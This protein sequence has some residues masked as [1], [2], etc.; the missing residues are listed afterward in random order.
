MPTPIFAFRLAET[1][2]AALVEMSKLYGAKNPSEFLREMVGAMCSG[3][4]ERVQEFNAR[5]IRAAGEQ[6]ILKLNAPLASS[7]E[8]P[9]KPPARLVKPKKKNRGRRG[10]P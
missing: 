10:P 4:P 6:L 9:R 2:Q 8:K 1:E 5:L 7:A 3:V